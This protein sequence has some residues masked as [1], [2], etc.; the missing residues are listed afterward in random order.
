M[1]RD[2]EGDARVIKGQR[3]KVFVRGNAGVIVVQRSRLEEGKRG[4]GRERQEKEK[5]RRDREEICF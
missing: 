3:S 2:D 1:T 4:K 5:M